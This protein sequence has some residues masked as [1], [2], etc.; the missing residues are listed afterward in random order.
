[1]TSIKDTIIEKIKHNTITPKTKLYFLIKKISLWL[2][3]VFTIFLGSLACSIILFSFANAIE[4]GGFF[5]S[6]PVI[7]MI[8]LAVLVLA[9]HL[10]VRSTE[11]GYKYRWWAIIVSSVI[12]SIILGSVLFAVKVGSFLD[13]A[14]A[15]R[16]SMYQAVPHQIE[17]R[18][19]NPEKGLLSGT[20]ISFK[21][22]I[23]T[24]RDKENTVWDIDITNTPEVDR[25]LLSQVQNI[26]IIGNIEDSNT[27]KACAF[28]PWFPLTGEFKEPKTNLQKSFEQEGIYLEI[29][30][31]DPV[32]PPNKEFI[33]PSERNIQ[34]VRNSLCRN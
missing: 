23:L 26:R 29:L 30:G 24:I 21:E 1:M 3:V 11:K 34:E 9:T 13:N 22:N 32:V 7:W 15:K 18:W 25:E 12:L 16:V 28:I 6:I 4:L 14:I 10:F 20:I 31:S 2:L 17:D 27:F 19:S 8:S 5:K 33:Y